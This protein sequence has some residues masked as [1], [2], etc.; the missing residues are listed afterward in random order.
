MRAKETRNC[1]FA[2]SQ[3]L[4]EVMGVMDVVVEL[5]WVRAGGAW[6]C[7]DTIA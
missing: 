2:E 6:E 5:F 4:M 7:L 1:V 3:M